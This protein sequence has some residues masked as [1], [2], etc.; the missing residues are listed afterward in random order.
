M[1]YIHT[2]NLHSYNSAVRDVPNNEYNIECLFLL[3]Q[4]KLVWVVTTP[5]YVFVILVTN[6]S[7]V[8]QNAFR[9]TSL[10]G[11]YSGT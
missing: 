11:R 6:L 3:P 10:K 2:N 1:L 7:H 8:P 9:M 4:A 5:C